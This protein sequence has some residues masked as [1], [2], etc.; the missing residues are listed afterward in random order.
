MRLILF[1]PPGAGKGTQAKIL[2]EKLGIPQLSTGDMFR[3]AI[4]NQTPL[5][6]KV[7]AIMDSGKLVSDD[8]VVEMVAET[9]AKPEFTAGYILDGFPR[10]VAQAEAFDTLLDSRTEHVDAFVAMEVPDEELI[11]RLVNRGQGREDDTPDKIKVRL[12]VYQQETAP[13]MAYYAEKGRTH[14]IDGLGSVDD[15]QNRI[16][17]AIGR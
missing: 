9:I 10:T 3:N 15:I 12:E 17:T 16:L 8:V 13:V 14:R 7:K 5:G 1:G 11:N 6:V 2:E 4:K